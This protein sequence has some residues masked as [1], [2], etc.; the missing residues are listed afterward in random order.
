[1]LGVTAMT[2]ERFHIHTQEFLKLPPDQEMEY[3]RTNPDY[4]AAIQETIRGLME[5][6][7]WVQF[8]NNA[9]TRYINKAL[10][11]ERS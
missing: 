9:V 6:G 5:R 7:E 4:A 2:P 10:V 1:M 3:I 11:H 8:W